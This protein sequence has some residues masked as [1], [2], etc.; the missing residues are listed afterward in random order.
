MAEQKIPEIIKEFSIVNNAVFGEKNLTA[1]EKQRERERE[2]AYFLPDIFY[3]F[4]H[5]FNYIYSFIIL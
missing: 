4:Y 1:N 5:F 2:R 3:F